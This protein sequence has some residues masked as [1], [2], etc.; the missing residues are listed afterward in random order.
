[1][2]DTTSKNPV[3]VEAYDQTRP[4]F[5]IPVSQLDHVRRV[6]DSHDLPYEVD[7]TAIALDGEPEMIVVNLGHEVDVHAVQQLLDSEP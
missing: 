5:W 2:I 1:M 6:L 7:D 4:F 3:A